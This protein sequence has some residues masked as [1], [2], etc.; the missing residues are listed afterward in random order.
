MTNE[1]LFAKGDIEALYNNNLKYMFSLRYKFKG[2]DWEELQSLCNLGFSKAVKKY[3]P[4]KNVK[5]ITYLAM[6]LQNEVFKYF[7]DSKKHANLVYL[8]DSVVSYKNGQSQTLEDTLSIEID[9]LENFICKEEN[10]EL[11]SALNCLS[12]REKAVMDLVL[13]NKTQVQISK[14][15]GV[16]QASISRIQKRSIN[17]IR[18]FLN[19][20]KN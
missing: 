16:Q 17:K 8:S 13:S 20:Y 5:F 3:S 2:M 10:E 1:E 19:G 6:C 4:D 12:N 7:K 18:R 15:I 11:K 9:F 14:L